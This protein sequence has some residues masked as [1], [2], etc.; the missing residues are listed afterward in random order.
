MSIDP[1]DDCTFYY[2]QEY[3]QTTGTASWQT[4][5]AAFKFP[6]CS[7]GP[8]GVLKGRVVKQSDPTQGIAGATIVATAS[9]TQ[10]V[11]TTTG[12]EGWFSTPLLVGTYDVTASAYAYLPATVSGVSVT[13]GVTTTMSDIPLTAASSYTVDGVVKDART[14]WPLYAKIVVE[15]APIDPIW[16]D[17]VTGA[18][19]VN[20]LA[21]TQFTFKV[22]DFWGGYAESQVVVGP[23][24]ANL[25]QDIFLE[26]DLQACTATGYKMHG[27]LEGFD[28]T[29]L[30][31]GW[32]VQH[33]S[34]ACD[35]SFNNPGARANL[36]GGAGNFAIA[37]SDACGSGTTMSSIL[38]SPKVD[39][40][41]LSQ[42]MLSFK[43]DYNNLASTE[44]AKVEVSANGGS[45]WS[46]VVNWG[47]ADMRGPATYT[48][49]VTSL[50][51][52]STQAQVR[53]TYTAPG[54]DWWWEL[55]DVFLG[56]NDC[57]PQAGGLVVG[58]V[59]DV[60]TDLPLLGATVQDDGLASTHTVITPLD[61]N[62]PDAFYTLFAPNGSRSI[63]ASM[64]QYA[65]GTANVTVPLSGTVGQDF[66]LGA[67]ILS[68]TPT[69]MDV[70]IA[71]GVTTTLPLTLTNSGSVTATYTINEI[72]NGLL[73][74]RSVREASIHRQA[75]PPAG[76]H[77][78]RRRRV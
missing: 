63:S 39:V 71:G 35:W 70:T 10:T 4:R 25:T 9:P 47:S 7:I 48:Q 72:D 76:S 51:S 2:T 50:L 17:P 73:T 65:S 37:D 34:G 31:A 38:Y 18:Y 21:G 56:L 43:Y 8:Q 26:P 55:D 24:T 57:A 12:A 53:F 62:V 23:L 69:S 14:G 15:G 1:V 32:T 16:T 30:P 75:F 67:G 13:E 29:S 54:W 28:S 6:S 42:I 3:I 66:A 41:T 19:S 5:V 77:L 58:S 52:G 60:N 78:P 36:T 40:S 33:V 68:Y 11:N 20:L 49:D 74:L 59:K 22:T 44:V 27:I 61:P 64:P 46:T 45:T